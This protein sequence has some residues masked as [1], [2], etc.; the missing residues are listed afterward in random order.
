MKRFFTG[1]NGDNLVY[2]GPE[3]RLKSVRRQPT[4]SPAD[5]WKLPPRKR[6]LIRSGVLSDGRRRSGDLEG[7]QLLTRLYT[8]WTAKTIRLSLNESTLAHRHEQRSCGNI[9]KREVKVAS[10]LPSFL[11]SLL[12]SP[13]AACL[14]PPASSLRLFRFWRTCVSRCLAILH[15]RLPV[16]RR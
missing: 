3:L 13:P 16:L 9:N 4:A 2:S 11:A 15:L 12:P 8:G 1:E 5:V 7:L 14:R 10:L 6:R